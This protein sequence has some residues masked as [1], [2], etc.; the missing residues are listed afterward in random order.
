MFKKNIL[1][2]LYDW[3]LHWSET[4]YGLPALFFIAFIESSVFPIPPDVL[5]IALAFGAPTKAFRF[6]LACTFG[7]VMGGMFGYFIG[8]AFYDVIGIRILEFYGFLD[9]FGMIKDLYDKYDIWIV[10]IA[11]FTPIPYKVFTIASGVFGMNFPEFVLVSF[12]SRGAR[13]FIVA[14]LIRKFGPP[15]KKF[16][17]K[18][19]DMISIA[20]VVILV[21]GFVLVK[22]LF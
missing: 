21:L 14:A 7:S 22:L 15:I 19:F 16:I 13:F 4:K 12:F 17:D 10:A 20:F 18:Y 6:A 11:G 1:R 8:M 9:K 5:L 3:V 2:N